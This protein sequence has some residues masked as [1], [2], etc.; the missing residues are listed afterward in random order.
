MYTYEK[1]IK[2]KNGTYTY[3]Y[4][5]HSERVNGVSKRVWEV[6]LGRKD[7]LKTNL[8]LI[9]RRLSK[10]PPEEQDFQF[11]LVTALYSICEDIDL[12]N[13]IDRCVDKREQGFSV[14]NY[15]AIL[16]INRAVAL[17][18][19]A[20][21][22]KWFDKTTLSRQFPNMSD[23]LTPQN[24]WNQMDHL[25]QVNI[26]RIEEL[27]CKEVV[28]KFNIKLDCFLFDPTNF[29][30]YIRDHEK[31]TIARRGHNKKKRNDLRQINV[32]LM[33]TRNDC[34]VPVMHETYEGNVPDVT[35]FKDAVQLMKSRFN[36]L[37]LELPTITLVFD[38]GNNS[39]IAYNLLNAKQMHFV[40][41]VRP[42]L[43][44]VKPL[45]SVPL[46]EYE[47]L[48]KKENG[49][50]V[51]GYRVTTDLYLGKKHENTLIVT[52]DGDTYALQKYNLDE[53]IAKATSALQAF[54]TT[55]LNTKSQWKDPKKV[56]KKVNRDILASK[57][58]RSLVV[59]SLV[60]NGDDLQLTWR[61]DD[62][63]RKMAMRE[64]GKTIIFSDRNEWSLVD[65]VKTYRSQK[66][67]EEQFKKLN[68]RNELSVMP[69]YHWTDQKIRV[70]VLISVL[71]LLI[72]NLL[73]RKMEAGGITESQ[74][75]CFTELKDIKEIRSYY[76]DGYPPDIKYT[77]MSTIQK[78]V[79]T[80][81]DLKRFMK[82]GSGVVQ[83]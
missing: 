2:T 46:S 11:G 63:A 12:I 68:K 1:N 57:E 35:H 79:S 67:V 58:L 56:A 32:S 77:R 72:S 39:E 24:I 30:T 61:I 17:N 76:D 20:R 54:A 49:R 10:T 47:L 70:H 60:A 69:M 40:S 44:K 31:N 16:A 73:Y 59:Y 26:R 27:L 38:K 9:K 23:A 37:G 81:L 65:I 51:S 43:T 82:P 36:A 66:G 29:F 75:E 13:I 18:S 25:D 33:V 6:N 3:V 50:K 8:P 80:L 4:L 14:G 83:N 71:A 42:S 48:W 55:T 28:A 45:L 62:D 64:L 15:L 41:S 7:D 74:E 19:K 21:V 52:F 53:R 34:N 5:A 78:K 22:Q